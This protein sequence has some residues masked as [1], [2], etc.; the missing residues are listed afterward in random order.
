MNT[1]NYV[2]SKTDV[3]YDAIYSYC[4]N[5]T[6]VKNTFKPYLLNRG[7]REDAIA[8]HVDELKQ[9]IIK[10][11]SMDKFPPITVDINTMQIVDGNC[12]FNALLKFMETNDTPMTLRVIYEDVPAEEFH[13][14][15][16][17]LNQGQKSWSTVDFIYHYSLRGNDNYKRLIEFCDEEE[18]LHDKGGKINPRYAAAALKIPVNSLK[19]PTLTLTEEQVAAGKRTLWEANEVRKKFVKDLKANGGGWLESYVRSYAEFRSTLGA[20]PFSDYLRE[21]GNTVKS[22]KSEVKVPFGSNKKGDWGTFFRAC[23]TYCMS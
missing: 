14:R 1:V 3:Q 16:I 2:P 12:R 20:I 7:G 6:D 19:T 8:K 9:V 5:E 17:Y 11:K 23:K 21:V 10:A 4:T 18:M 13:D 22:R 15:V